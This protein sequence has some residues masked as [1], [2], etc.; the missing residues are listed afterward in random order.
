[1]IRA[2]TPIHT[3]RFTMNPN[4]MDE[5]L[6]T[7]GQA[8]R[9]VVE[10]HKTDMTFTSEVIEG[11]TY[12]FGAYSLSQSETNRFSSDLPVDIQVRVLTTTGQALASQITRQQVFDVLNDEV[13]E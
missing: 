12:Y 7:Y 6:V 3:F 9:I 13:L 10:K 8:D 5:V 11:V 2:T 1:M 4:T